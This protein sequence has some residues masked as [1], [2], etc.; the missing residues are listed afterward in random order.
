[1]AAT[2]LV[3]TAQGQTHNARPGAKV[4]E[5]QLKVG[6]PE[7]EEGGGRH[8]C[9]HSQLLGDCGNTELW[10]P[11]YAATVGRGCTGAAHSWLGTF[12]V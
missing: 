11:W 3:T 6:G 4:T 7:A 8:I 2:T 10:G 12:S 1:M 9:K 5:S